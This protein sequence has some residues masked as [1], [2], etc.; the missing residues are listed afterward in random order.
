MCLLGNL[1]QTLLFSLF[2]AAH[3]LFE[4]SSPLLTYLSGRLLVSLFLL[5]LLSLLPFA[6]SL[7]RK[8]FPHFVDLL[9]LSPVIDFSV[10]LNLLLLLSTPPSPYLDLLFY[11]LLFFSPPM[12]LQSKVKQINLPLQLLTLLSLV[13]ELIECLIGNFLRNRRIP[14]DYMPSFNLL[15]KINNG[16]GDVLVRSLC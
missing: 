3:I 7:F 4:V 5:C 1:F 13:F 9:L 6:L 15:R 12:L 8:G 11:P 16:L 14:D 10:N 2:Q